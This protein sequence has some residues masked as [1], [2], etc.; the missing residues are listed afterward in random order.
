MKT[1]DRRIRRLEGQIWPAAQPDFLRH[2][3]QHIRVVV[4]ALGRELNLEESTCQRS[5]DATGLLT[6]IVD[7]NGSGEGLSQ[8]ELDRFVAS[9]PVKVSGTERAT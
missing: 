1:V 2:P 4:S 3:R 5:L 7:L 8:E 9:F 6:E